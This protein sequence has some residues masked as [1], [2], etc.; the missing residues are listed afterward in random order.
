MKCTAIVERWFIQGNGCGTEVIDSD[1]FD[2]MSDAVKRSEE[3][4]IIYEH[5]GSGIF[6]DV[7][8]EMED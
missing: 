3:F 2:N 7:I 4:H 1:A 5:A 6:H 8:V